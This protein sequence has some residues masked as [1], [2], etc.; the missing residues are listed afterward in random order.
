MISSLAVVS[1]AWTSL[2]YWVVF[3]FDITMD[4][5][6]VLFVVLDSVVL[7]A[8]DHCTCNCVDSA[9]VALTSNTTG[10]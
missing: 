3:V 8:T 4:A 9:P 1:E 2:I 6:A 10:P 5:T 7:V